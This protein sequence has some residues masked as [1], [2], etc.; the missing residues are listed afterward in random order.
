MPI[1]ISKEKR[2]DIVKHM[3]ARESKEN[4]AKWMFVCIKTVMRIWNKYVETGTY[5]P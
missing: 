3:Q 5:K 4:I 2:A 1:P